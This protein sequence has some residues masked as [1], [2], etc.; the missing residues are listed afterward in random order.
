MKYIPKE[1]NIL[2]FKATRPVAF[3]SWL[4]QQCNNFMCTSHSLQSPQI[5][6]IPFNK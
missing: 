1:A 2:A 3:P 5:L 6:H 4:I